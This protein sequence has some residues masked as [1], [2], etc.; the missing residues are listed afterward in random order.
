[1]IH[2][3]EYAL[4]LKSVLLNDRRR[5]Q[6]LAH[7]RDLALPDCW[8]GAGFIRDGVWDLLSG[9]KTGEISNDVDIIWFDTEQI[10]PQLDI[11]IEQRLIGM[12]PTILWSVK[13]QGRMHRRNGDE[14]YMSCVHALSFWPETATAVAARLTQSSEIE[15]LA[16]FGLDDLFQG[17]IRPTP[18]FRR[19]KLDVFEKR[20]REKGWLKK[21]PML[22]VTAD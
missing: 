1:M 17:I 3:I 21:W 16:P 9:H 15:I 13:N 8:I 6:I 4:T 10:C 11:E 5:C 12:D 22:R 20:W 18:R 2:S 14:P 7:V 19:G